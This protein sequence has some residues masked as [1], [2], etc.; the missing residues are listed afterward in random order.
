M[1]HTTLSRMPARRILHACS[2]L[3]LALLLQAA[4]AATAPTD[5]EIATLRS[6]IKDNEWNIAS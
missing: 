5:R 2:L 1:N 4:N 3:L 6:A